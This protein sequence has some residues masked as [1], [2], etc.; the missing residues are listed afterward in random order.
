ME[1][2]RWGGNDDGECADR[3]ERRLPP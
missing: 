3:G 1:F 2:L